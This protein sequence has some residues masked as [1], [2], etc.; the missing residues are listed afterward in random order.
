MAANYKI[1]ATIVEVVYLNS[2]EI[3]SFQVEGN[4]LIM[5]NLINSKT[6]N[7]LKRIF[8]KNPNINTIIMGEVEGSVDDEANLQAAKFIAKKAL[9]TKLLKNSMVAS[10]GTD[11]FLAGKKRIIENGAQV[12]V[13]SWS[14]G[15]NNATYF[16]KGHEFHQPYID[17]YQAI[18]W[19]KADAEKFYYYTINAASS[20]E[21]H[22]MS[23]KEL[24][25]Y[26]IVT[27]P[28]K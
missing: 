7:Q 10:G 15:F 12:G 3:T 11:F 16:P 14:D 17:Y 6:P 9:T 13:H 1:V 2:R 25:E 23:N 28:I 26:K 21:I 20:D 8:V 19:S 18:G 5:S 4:T 24:K 22:T 27:E